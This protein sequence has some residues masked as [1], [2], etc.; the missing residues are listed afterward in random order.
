MIRSRYPPDQV[1][2]PPYIADTPVVRDHFSRYLAEITYYDGQVGQ[3]LDLLDKHQLRD[4]TLVMV[5]SEQGNSFPFAKWTC[6]DM[7][8]HSAMIVRWPGQVK[9]GSVSD[10]MVE[11]VD[12]TPTFVEAAGGKGLP[13]LDGKS[14]LPVLL[15]ETDRHKDLV[16]GIHTTRG[17]IN[18]SECLSD[19]HRA[20]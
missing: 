14:F 3:I 2:L 16:F 12:I 11:Y 15:G 10:A 18:G 9:A 7:G 20:R 5:V 6:Y 4:D 19:S 1:Q 13:E 17:I 8:L